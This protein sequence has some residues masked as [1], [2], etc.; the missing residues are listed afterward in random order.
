MRPALLI[1]AAAFPLLAATPVRHAPAAVPV[2]AEQAEIA[3]IQHHFDGALELLSVRDLSGLTSAQRA[4]RA[5]AAE[6]LAKYRDRGLFPHNYDFPG[7]AVPY[8][9]DRKTGVVC[10]LGNLIEK[11][12]RRDLVDRVAKLNNNV[13]V[14]ELA[15]DKEF[16]AWLDE[17]GL[18]LYEAARIQ[19]P[20]MMPVGEARREGNAL[21]G[22][23]GATTLSIGV[24]A[25]TLLVPRLRASRKAAFVGF[26]VNTLALAAT[27]NADDAL[28]NSVQT[29]ALATTV[30]GALVATRTLGRYQVA[31]AR[32]RATISPIIPTSASQGAGIS[33]SF[34]F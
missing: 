18:T 28:P 3:R 16:R 10:A 13:W 15:E 20:Y 21:V 26:A 19:M 11:S 23:A 1:A 30:V 7:R 29:A 22:A 4:N 9:V 2:D 6:E 34:R 17:N 14:Y 24:T 12:G 33:V 32:R 25:T 5:R 8:F 31:E 27:V